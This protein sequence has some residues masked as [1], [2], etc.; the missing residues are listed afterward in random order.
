M[1]FTVKEADPGRRGRA[2]DHDRAGRGI[3]GDLA[4][5]QAGAAGVEP[6]HREG[7]IGRRAA[8][9]VD[10]LVVKSIGNAGGKR[11]RRDPQAGLTVSVAAVVVASG[12]VPLVKTARY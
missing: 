9:D 6:A 3:G 5:G 11:G 1:T 2:V 12:A 4:T 10:R 8:A 7:R